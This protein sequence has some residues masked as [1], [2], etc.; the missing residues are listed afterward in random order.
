MQKIIGPNV[1][2]EPGAKIDD[3]DNGGVGL[4][5]PVPTERF[6]FPDIAPV[7]EGLPPG[8]RRHGLLVTVHVGYVRVQT[9]PPGIGLP[10]V[11]IP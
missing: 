3:I 7:Q 4:V 6:E 2:H 8:L 5:R 11:N 9:V 10:G 1:T